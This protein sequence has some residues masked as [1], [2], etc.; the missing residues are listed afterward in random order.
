[1]FILRSTSRGTC[2]VHFIKTLLEDLLTVHS[3]RTKSDI[4]SDS[5]T[6]LPEWIFYAWHSTF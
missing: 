4:A 1:M 6:N 3:E 2:T 5:K